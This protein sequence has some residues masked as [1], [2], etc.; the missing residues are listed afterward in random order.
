MAFR[1]LKV[2]KKRIQDAA[3]V[4]LIIQRITPQELRAAFPDK[5]IIKPKGIEHGKG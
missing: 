3:K 4:L 2:H 1:F 5:E